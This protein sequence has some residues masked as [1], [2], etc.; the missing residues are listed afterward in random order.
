MRKA[1]LYIMG[2]LYIGAGLNHFVHPEFYDRMMPAIL[3]FPRQ[4]AYLSGIME[5]LLGAGLMIPATRRFAAWGVIAL[6]IGVFPANV[7]MA[8]H[9]SAWGLSVVY[10]F[11]RLPL[12]LL[13]IYW[14]YTYTQ[15]S[16]PP[17]P[18][19]PDSLKP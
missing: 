2:V 10:L 6:L 17:H 5:L 14:A 13:L 16:I 11:L 12:Q 8:V 9:A 19:S 7:N 15:E 18:E 3:P 1:L 4:L